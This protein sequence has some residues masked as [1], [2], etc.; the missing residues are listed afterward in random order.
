MLI[1]ISEGGSVTAGANGDHGAVFIAEGVRGIL[2][3]DVYRNA[4]HDKDLGRWCEHR[5]RRWS[6]AEDVRGIHQADA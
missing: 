3:A 6:P 5:P 4:N 2:Q 1:K